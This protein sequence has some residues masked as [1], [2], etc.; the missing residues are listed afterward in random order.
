MVVASG[1]AM[2]AKL[3]LTDRAMTLDTD[4]MKEH[5]AH[6]RYFLYFFLNSPRVESALRLRPLPDERERSNFQFSTMVSP[7][8]GTTDLRNYGVMKKSKFFSVFACWG[9]EPRKWSWQVAWLWLQSS[10]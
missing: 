5:Q 3:A 4:A 8:G 1:M 9:I 2:A 10:L 6:R 7:I